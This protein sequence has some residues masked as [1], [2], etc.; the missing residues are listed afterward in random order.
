MTIPVIPPKPKKQTPEE[1][2]KER[3]TAAM[4]IVSDRMDKILHG[5]EANNGRAQTEYDVLNKR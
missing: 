4:K 2:Q 1:Y 3:D 5:G